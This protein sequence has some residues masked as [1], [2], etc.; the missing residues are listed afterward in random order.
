MTVPEG[1]AE[2]AVERTL[3]TL[4]QLNPEFAQPAAGNGAFPAAPSTLPG[5]P[6]VG[7]AAAPSGL[8]SQALCQYIS[9]ANQCLER[10][11]VGRRQ[12]T[13]AGCGKFCRSRRLSWWRRHGH[14]ER[15]P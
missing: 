9:F 14:R 4:A 8:P 12:A 6:A 3:G 11:T 1:W 2:S 13:A 7:A 5:M 10:R 15:A